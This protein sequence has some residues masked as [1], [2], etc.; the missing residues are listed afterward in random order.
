MV[1]K[2]NRKKRVV[3]FREVNYHNYTR[4]CSRFRCLW[5]GASK[6]QGVLSACEA[7]KF[8]AGPSSFIKYNRWENCRHAAGFK[9]QE[10]KSTTVPRAN[11][12]A[13]FER[14]LP[15][16]IDHQW[17]LKNDKFMRDRCLQFMEASTLILYLDFS[18]KYECKGVD[19]ATSQHSNSAAQLV[20]MVYYRRAH[21]DDFVTD[22]VHCWGDTVKGDVDQDAAYYV[23]CLEFI[24]RLYKAEMQT[25]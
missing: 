18:A 25:E 2:V 14:E 13:S 4:L 12:L 11:F 5:C 6:L 22:C 7:L 10:L 23:A 8:E 15:L 19:V 9:N 1:K 20:V 3:S 21:G 16:M 24:V 17:M